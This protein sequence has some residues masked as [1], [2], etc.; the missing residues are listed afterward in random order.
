MLKA[1][2]LEPGGQAVDACGVC[3][4]CKRIARGV[5]ADVLQVGPGDTGA[6]KVDQVR[7]AI[8]RT[9][10]RPFEG[11]RR[12]VI[13]DEADALMIGA[14]D[15]LLKTLEEPPPAS[16][17]VLVTSRPDVLLPTVR[18]RCHR[19][20]FGRLAPAEVAAV[21]MCE[22]RLQRGGRACGR[23][24]VG[25]QRRRGPRRGCRRLRGRA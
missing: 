11:R 22:P 1:P 5:H 7:E 18:S 16:V 25:R 21:L 4:S 6:I 10:Y 17:F 3:A 24:V 13:I 14:Q 8:E 19:L 12:V 9:A 23:V 15:A 2:P 20:R